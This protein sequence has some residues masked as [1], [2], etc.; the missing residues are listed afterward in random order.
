MFIH[1]SYF[2]LAIFAL[3]FQ[4]NIQG[5]MAGCPF[6]YGEKDQTDI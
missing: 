2:I 1:S 3:L 4:V 6:G 5:I